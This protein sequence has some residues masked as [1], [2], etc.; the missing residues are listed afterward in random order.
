M[1]S[2]TR[3]QIVTYGPCTVLTKTGR[4]TGTP[5][6]NGKYYGL[7]DGTRVGVVT[8]NGAVVVPGT[9]IGGCSG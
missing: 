7:D 4:C 6:Y 3:P 1:K 2:W 8:V 5:V 9:P